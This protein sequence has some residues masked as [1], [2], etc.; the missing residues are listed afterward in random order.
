VI[1]ER[2]HEFARG[3]ADE[4]FEKGNHALFGRIAQYKRPDIAGQNPWVLAESV[5]FELMLNP[6]N[7]GGLLFLRQNDHCGVIRPQTDMTNE[8]R[9]S[10]NRIHKIQ[11]A[12]TQNDSAGR[13]CSGRTRVISEKKLLLLIYGPVRTVCDQLG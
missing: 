13:P 9:D 6:T 2:I 7:E 11:S 10:Q 4:L 1:F 5:A 12:M 3:R 8:N